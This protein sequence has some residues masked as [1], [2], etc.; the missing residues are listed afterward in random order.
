MDKLYQ[1]YQT[2]CLQ[3]YMM[4]TSH[5]LIFRRFYCCHY[6]YCIRLPGN[7]AELYTRN[8]VHSLMFYPMKNLQ[9]KHGKELLHYIFWSKMS[10]WIWHV[11]VSGLKGQHQTDTSINRVG[12]EGFISRVILQQESD[13]AG[14][15][16]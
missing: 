15:S 5:I 3:S 11:T 4:W 14:R 13:R 12:P 9:I 1:A 10:T 6:F 7:H 8:I 16:L 2:H